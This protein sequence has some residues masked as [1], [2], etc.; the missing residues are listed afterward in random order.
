ME[1]I[2]TSSLQQC[3]TFAAESVD[4]REQYEN[5]IK[6]EVFFHHRRIQSDQAI[7]KR[8]SICSRVAPTPVTYRGLLRFSQ[9]SFLKVLFSL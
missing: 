9:E 1:D 4:I 3:E 8:N 2:L 5:I 6:V 7:E